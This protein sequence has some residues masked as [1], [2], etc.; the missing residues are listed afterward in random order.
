MTAEPLPPLD[1]LAI[2]GV[3]REQIDWVQIRGLDGGMHG[4]LW[5][6]LLSHYG[7]LALFKLV[8]VNPYV[9]EKSS[10][11]FGYVSSPRYILCHV[12]EFLVYDTL[13]LG[14]YIDLKIL[15]KR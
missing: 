15:C 12:S 7:L 11:D 1:D 10:G 5:D 2:T 14:N 9:V 4:W 8:F 3:L 6:N 13:A